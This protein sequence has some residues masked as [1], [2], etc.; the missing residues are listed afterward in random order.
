MFHKTL[1]LISFCFNCFLVNAQDKPKVEYGKI[2]LQTLTQTKFDI[3]STAD[4][5]VL[6]EK[7]T[8]NFRYDEQ[9][10]F[11]IETEFFIRKKII[12]QSALELGIVKIPIYR[13]GAYY[14]NQVLRYFKGNTFYLDNGGIQ[15]SELTQ[16]DIFEEKKA[17]KY[18]IS[19][20]TFPN[21][22]EGSII[23]YSYTIVTPLS[24]RDKPETWYFQ[25][26]KPT[27][28]SEIE[29][30]IPSHFYYQ[31]IS[32]G[33][34]DLKINTKENV[35]VNMGHSKFDTYGLKYNFAMQNVPA[36]FNES[37][38][39][40]L[41]D[42]VA[43]IE[44]ELS[45]VSLPGQ[46]IKNYSSTWEN[47]NKTLLTS[48]NFGLRIRKSSYLKPIVDKFADITDKKEKL[49]KVF[50]FM[51]QQI[52]TNKDYQSIYA[53]DLKKVFEN[54][55]GTATEQNLILLSLLREMGYEANPVI[56]STRGNGK[57]NQNFA[58]LDRFNY[59]VCRVKLD[60]VFYLLDISD[61]ILK[62]G[63]LPFECLNGV[64]RE[65]NEAGGQFVEL[66]SGDKFKTYDFIEAKIDLEAG[67]IV[68]KLEQSNSGYEG[69]DLRREFKRDGIEK[70]KE[71]IVQNSK[72]MTV[73]NITI[74]NLEDQEKIQVVKLDFETNDSIEDEDI[75]YVNP[76]LIGKISENPFK[77]PERIYPVE[78]GCGSE[79]TY[80]I[81]L[82]IPK[83]FAVESLPKNANI[84]LSDKSAQFFYSCSFDDVTN[85]ITLI[86]KLMI[87]NPVYF[88]D[89][90][91]ELRE[92]Y[93][94][95]VQKYEDQIVLKRK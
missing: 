90:Y 75:L 61:P 40:S 11:L 94:R 53:Q 87:K 77:Q 5:I 47:L 34:L 71:Q 42:F 58:L 84:A 8:T 92:L 32:S 60:D 15:K 74:E 67:K 79:S 88:A 68:G 69:Y 17:D 39:S 48:D 52:E 81:V 18:F 78:F 95:I 65:I 56:L 29:I 85:K 59:T 3:D 93:N 36:F 33:Y 31:M 24:V 62:M 57:I 35:S 22:K 2:S 20:A 82:E 64:G 73:S 43:K 10:G 1:L 19:K 76:I 55:K 26:N 13:G 4:A 63:M 45:T 49:A 12:K 89:Q 41:E 46:P 9:I 86:T 66:I 6:F 38:I 83:E 37:Y 23:E 54:K 70:M 50:Y 14:N 91:Q 27:L 25:G 80:K 51:N 7:S 72:E 44:F 21:V 28:W 16:R 30:T